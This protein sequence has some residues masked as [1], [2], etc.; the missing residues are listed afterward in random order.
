MVWSLNDGLISALALLILKAMEY[1]IDNT[2]GVDL[3]T[4]LVAFCFII[5]YFDQCFIAFVP[6]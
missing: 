6:L 1:P 3:W 5:V 2:N 4:T